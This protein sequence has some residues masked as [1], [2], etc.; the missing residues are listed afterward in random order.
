M[1][2]TKIL[3]TRGQNRIKSIHVPLSIL[4]TFNQISFIFSLRGALCPGHHSSCP[5]EGSHAFTRPLPELPQRPHHSPVAAGLEQRHP[6]SSLGQQILSGPGRP[7]RGCWDRGSQCPTPA[8]TLVEGV[9][10]GS[11]HPC[12][13]SF[14]FLTMTCSSFPREQVPH[15]GHPGTL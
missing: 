10:L 1:K 11:A 5:Q 9:A 14:C 4:L 12:R 7:V 3:Q 8:P 13:S 6:A 15:S 2:K